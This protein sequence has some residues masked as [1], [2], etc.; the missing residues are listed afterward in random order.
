MTYAIGFLIAFLCW[1]AQDDA[2]QFSSIA[3]APMVGDCEIGPELS[4]MMQ[5]LWRDEGLQL[6][7]Q[8]SREYQLNDSAA[9]YLNAL[10]RISQVTMTT[11]HSV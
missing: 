4:V 9:Y 2:R 11:C 5:R 6:C 7:F 10:E 8:R 1:L 3:G